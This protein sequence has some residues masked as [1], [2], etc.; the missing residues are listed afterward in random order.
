MGK[1]WGRLLSNHDRVTLAAWVDPD[2]AAL[3]ESLRQVQSTGTEPLSHLR[4]AIQAGVGDFVVDVTPPDVHES[5]AVEAMEFGLPVLGEKPLA[6]SMESAARIVAC[7]QRTGVLHAVSQNRRYNRGLH[8]FRDCVRQIGPPQILAA[9]FFIGPHFGGFRDEME[10][11]LLLDMAIHT[12]DAARFILKEDAT[13]VLCEEF[14]PAGSWYRGNACATA[15]F[16]FE[17]GA[18]F[19]FRGSWCAE[20]LPTSWDSEW[21]CVC[22]GGSAKWNGNEAPSGE[23]VIDQEGFLH[24]VEPVEPDEVSVT[25][26]IAGPLADFL[27]FL[28]GGPKPPTHCEDN[29]KSLAMVFAAQRS[30][31]EGRPVALA[32]VMPP[33]D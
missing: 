6:N 24:S 32:E 3:E 25:E 29:L 1:G 33:C 4:E 15:S 2:R 30:A 18:R 17:S 26:W 27:K 9:D 23:R 20:G 22:Q 7:S 16:R 19:L 5:I 10:S 8:Q 28:E 21:R 13:T 11:P 12:F 14:N 31:K